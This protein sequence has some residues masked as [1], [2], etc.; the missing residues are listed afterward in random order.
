VI[1]ALVSYVTPDIDSSSVGGADDSDE[2][3]DEDMVVVLESCGK[4]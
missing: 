1:F 2:V 4:C 3:S